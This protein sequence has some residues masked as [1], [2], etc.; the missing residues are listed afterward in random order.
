MNHTSPIAVDTQWSVHRM[1]DRPATLHPESFW[2]QRQLLNR[3]ACFP[4]GLS[5]LNESGVLRNFRDWHD[6]A[7]GRFTGQ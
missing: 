6:S 7:A 5:M 4:H 1:L 2:G 3:Q